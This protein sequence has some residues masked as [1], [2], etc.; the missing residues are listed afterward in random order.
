MV[1][2]GILR[3]CDQ[4]HISVIWIMSAVVESFASLSWVAPL[5]ESVQGRRVDFIGFFVV[6]VVVVAVVVVVVVVQ[7]CRNDG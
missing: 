2:T 5:N 4:H 7:L 1:R 6:V 3:I